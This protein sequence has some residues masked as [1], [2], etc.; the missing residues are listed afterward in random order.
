MATSAV[1]PAEDTLSWA[2]AAV[3][4]SLGLVGT[5]GLLRAGRGLRGTTLLAPW[6]WACL[7]FA[8]LAF[9]EVLLACQA[10]EAASLWPFHVRYLAGTTTLAPYVALL[11]AKRPQDRAWQWIVLALLVFLALPSGKALL[12]NDGGRPSPHTAWRMLLAVLLAS[13]L[14]NHLPTR[15]WPSAALLSLA[16]LAWLVGY[17]P[18]GDA[19]PFGYLPLAGLAPATAAIWLAHW[20]APKARSR[21]RPIDRVWLDFR[22][23]YGALW[24]LRVAE[25]FNA[26]AAKYGWPAR[27]AWDG[28]GAQEVGGEKRAAREVN[29]RGQELES[30]GQDAGDEATAAMSEHLNALLLRFVSREWIRHR[31]GRDGSY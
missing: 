18:G 1:A 19:V 23:A 7:S 24:A 17:L 15:F 26:S 9:G 4:L 16:Q 12:F 14:V 27:L 22:D 13:Q 30:V 11:G 25:R 21:R 8:L 28:L 31:L 2:I 10:C 5:T 20:P 29:C 6:R 3:T